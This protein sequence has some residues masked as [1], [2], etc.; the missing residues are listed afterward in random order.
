M[1]NGCQNSNRTHKTIEARK[2]KRSNITFGQ[3]NS[4][5][6]THANP[7]SN[8]KDDNFKEEFIEEAI[9]DAQLI[10][11]STQAKKQFRKGMEKEE[12]N[13]KKEWIGIVSKGFANDSDSDN[14]GGAYIHFIRESELNSK[15][16]YILSPESPLNHEKIQEAKFV[17]ENDE[18][19]SED[20][21]LK[22]TITPFFQSTEN[23]RKSELKEEKRGDRQEKS[24]FEF[25]SSQFSQQPGIQSDTKEFQNAREIIDNS[26]FIN[27]NANYF[28][29]Y[30]K[31]TMLKKVEEDK[32]SSGSSLY[33]VANPERKSD[34]IQSRLANSKSVISKNILKTI[35]RSKFADPN[36]IKENMENSDS[37]VGGKERK[38]S[39]INTIFDPK[40]NTI[41]LNG[42]GNDKNTNWGT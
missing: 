35:D 39:Y 40:D 10:P 25:K 36:Q 16:N 21:D 42:Q 27:S 11:F 34:R 26:N 15:E 20:N 14:D 8:K 13:Q 23:K 6:T 18:L 4:G 41:P 1:G 22:R 38:I 33:Q 32:E 9:K 31:S 3:C 17:D 24:K 28:S 2:L 29:S 19:D 37:T 12:E 30:P 5:H 7:F